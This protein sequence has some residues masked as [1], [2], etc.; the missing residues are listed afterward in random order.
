[1][2]TVLLGS[3]T[4]RAYSPLTMYTGSHPA[5]NYPRVIQLRF[6][7]EHNG[8]MYAIFE[9]AVAKQ[10]AF[11]IFESTDNGATWK[12][13][14][15]LADSVN[16]WGMRYQPFL[17]ELPQALGQMPAGTIL[18]AGNAIPSDMTRTKI[19]IYKSTDQAR[20]WTFLSSVAT[21]T[22]ANPD[23]NFDPVWES[24]L[25]LANGKLICYYSD[26]RDSAHNQKIVH[27]TSSDG[28]HWSGLVNDI[29]L[30]DPKLRPGMPVIAR[31]KDGRYLM[32]Y[33]IV[34]LSKTAT[35]FQVSKNPEVWKPTDRG[36]RIAAGGTPYVV[37]MPD[38][39]LV[40]SEM[41][42]NN[43]Y[44]NSSNG[45]GPWKKVTSP[46]GKGYSRCLLPLLNGRLFLSSSI[47]NTIQYAEID[48]NG[49]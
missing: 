12:Q 1:M 11:Q 3:A 33:E 39:K 5:P 25:L 28:V 4:L 41:Q 37:T 21:G 17:Y 22:N 24:F 35:Y 10:P 43:L 23:G 29:A 20:T 30:I 32:S 34:G 15:A 48:V 18:C 42:D 38:G 16:G 19:D 26:E 14:S 27:Q 9:H 44:V 8:R 31:M 40:I 13:V 46:L 49:K 47:G 2:F 45:S 36:T 6:S 7:G